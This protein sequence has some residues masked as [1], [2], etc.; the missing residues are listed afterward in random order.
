MPDLLSILHFVVASVLVLAAADSLARASVPRGIADHLLRLLLLA[1]A[2][3]ILPTALLGAL[4]WLRGEALLVV[5]A[6]LWLAS[7]GAETFGW[8]LFRLT[9]LTRRSAVERGALLFAA[10]VLVLDLAAVLP[11]VPTDWDAMT[12]HLYFPARWLQAGGIV[13]V[14]TVFAD[15]SAAFAPQN[16]AL[17]FA[18]QMALLGV[19]RTVDTSQLGALVLLM[20]GL[21]RLARAL[22]ARRGP[23]I[24]AAV[25]LAVVAPLRR[26]TYSAHVDVLI[27]AF[28]LAGFVLALDIVRQ[29]RRPPRPG[30]RATLLLGGLAVGLT[31][32]TKTLGLPLALPVAGWVG[33]VLLARRR[34]TDLGLYGLAALGGGGFWYVR[35]L[36]AYGNPLFPLDWNVLGLHFDGAYTGDAVRRG[37]FHVD[38][39]LEWMAAIFETWGA[40][41]WGFLLLGVGV[42]ARQVIVTLLRR[43]DARALLSPTFAVLAFALFWSWM[44]Y[45]VIPHNTQTRFAFPLL[46][47]ASAGW[48]RL[49]EN[50][51]RVRPWLAPI[52]AVVGIAALWTSS[53]PERLWTTLV[54]ERPSRVEAIERAPF[55]QWTAGV[56]A[57]LELAGDTPTRIAYSGANVPYAMMGE[58]WMH[59]VVY[60]ETQGEQ[61]DGFFEHWRRAP[62]LYDTYQ[63]PVYRG[64]DDSVLWREHLER[65]KI[66]LVAV[67]TLHSAERAW[68]KTDEDG[69]PV[70]RAWMRALPETFELLFE[71]DDAEIFRFR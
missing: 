8:H 21:Y 23:A 43:R 3:I 40:A 45:I 36:L 27:T 17:F 63:P 30:A 1:H 64:R 35:N 34:F 48:A 10:L 69:F 6:L 24:L 38:T 37:I 51:R 42:L 20:A 58:G 53:R 4:G 29:A 13:H 44:C 41:T 15:N 32:G 56:V 22:G 57:A 25:T 65:E 66:E 11:R 16:G 47:A 55:R 9:R 7:R 67:F 46:L 60:V 26:W 68:I 39:M 12:Y 59:R 33:A 31:V 61:G 52:L 28:W 14:P 49:L 71:D 70:E 18:W 50:G 62:R 19:D 5:A 2:L 54:D